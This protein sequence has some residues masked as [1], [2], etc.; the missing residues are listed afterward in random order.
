MEKI[1]EKDAFQA[2][3]E[4]EA[5]VEKLQAEVQH[6]KQRILLSGFNFTYAF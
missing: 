3:K 5:R 1:K 2:A 4:A 6:L